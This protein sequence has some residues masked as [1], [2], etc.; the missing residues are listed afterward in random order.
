MDTLT[1]AYTPR[2]ACAELWARRD[3]EVLVCG[4]A[5]TGKSRACLE[6]LH[7]MCLI[8]PGMRALMARKTHISLTST[9][10]V[11]YRE[12]V[13]KEA[14]EN[15]DVVWFGGNAQEPPCYRYSNGSRIIVCGLDKNTRIMS[16]EYD[17][18]YVQEATE[19][20]EDDWDALVTRLR[21]G[22]ISFQQILADCNPDK[23]THWL[24][25]RCDRGDTLLL[26]SVHE[27]N[28][29]FFDADG[30]LTAEGVSYIE[31]KLDKLTGVNKLRLRHGKWAAAEGIIYEEWSD[32][33]HI[34]EKM[35]EG[36]ESW[37]RWWSVDFGF[38]N[39]FVLQCWAEDPDGRLHLYREL[40]HTKKLV[41][42]HIEDILNI[43]APVDE[44]GRRVWNEPKPRAIICDHD[45][46]GR[47]QF[48][49]GLGRSTKA[50]NKKVT[51]GLQAVAKRLR[52]AAD[53]KP[54]LFILKNCVVQ[55]DPDLA[56]KKKPTCTAEEVA[57][58]VWDKDKENPVK[59]NDHGCDA[60]RYIVAERDLGGR[61][62][63]R[64]M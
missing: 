25:A 10:L 36:W 28:P 48:E 27:D 4:P 17:V 45:A 39:P 64:W 26:T 51:Q 58:Y 53:G 42:D 34:I 32:G 18:I 2:G 13:A 37:T 50:A 9:G 16:S 57:G 20:S 54:R 23:P 29:V 40:Y 5:G 46:E 52:I 43:V 63:V 12:K 55:R 3:P 56:A 22:A 15:G 35:P 24:K 41:A 61:P 44:D 21:N 60:K 6:K 14:I 38:T 19:I 31:G 8:N 33:V 7:L 1:H 49:K 47:A 59:E 11:T 30:E 62:N